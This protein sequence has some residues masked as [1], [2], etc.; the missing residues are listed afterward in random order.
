MID[1]GYNYDRLREKMSWLDI[2]PASINH[3][4]ITHQDTDHI[5]ALEQDSDLLFQKA[6]ICISEIENRYMIGEARRKVGFGMYRLPMVKSD[7]RRELLKDRDVFYI[8]EIKVQAIFCPRHTWGR[9]VYLIDDRYLFTGDTIWFGAGGGY[10]F[11]GSLAES[12]EVAVKSLAALEHKLRTRGLSPMIITGHTGWTDSLDYAFAHRDQVC[13]G[14]RKQKPHDPRAPYDGY[15]KSDDTEENVRSRR[16]EK[17]NGQG[18]CRFR[19]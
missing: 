1:A 8:Y 14:W 9:M 4:M 15:D 5:G 18:I 11:L 19:L 12:N 6:T 3:I 2:D 10:S 16:S 13:K 7:N 17:Q